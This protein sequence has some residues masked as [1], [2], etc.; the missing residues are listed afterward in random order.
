MKRKSKTIV[1]RAAT[2]LL[3]TM[4]TLLAFPTKASAWEYQNISGTGGANANEQCANLFDG[5]T[6]TKWCVIDVNGR[7]GFDE[8]DFVDRKFPI[9]VEFSTSTA[10][11]PT[12]YVLTTGN[13]SGIREDENGAVFNNSGRRPK[14]WVIWAKA[15]PNDNWEELTTVED[16]NSLPAESC[17]PTQYSIIIDKSYQFFRFEITEIQGGEVFELSEFQLLEANHEKLLS[18]ATVLDFQTSYQYTGNAITI[19]SFSLKDASG[20]DI[21]SSNY[22]YTIKNSSNE[23]VQTV[24][25]LGVYTLEISAIEGSEYSGTK[26]VSFQVV[27]WAGDGG[28]CGNTLENVYYEIATIDDKKTLTIR[29]SP[30]ATTDDLSMK[31]YGVNPYVEG[32]VF[33]PWINAYPNYAFDDGESYFDYWSI[34]CDI[35]EVVIEEGVTS[36]G[37]GSFINC[38]YLTSVTIP[39]SV[40]SIGKRTFSDS[41]LTSITIP[42]SVTSIGDNAFEGC[43][44]LSTITIPNSVTS[45]GEYAFSWCE[46]LSTITI[47]N[48]VTSIGRNAFTKC[49]NIT[50]VYC[51]ANPDKLNWATCDYDFHEN[52]QFHVYKNQLVNYLTKFSNARAQ[53][54]GDIEAPKTCVIT[55]TAT[56]NSQTETETSGVHELPYTKKLSDFIISNNPESA[57]QKIKITNI[58][59][60]GDNVVVGA[61]NGWDASFTVTDEGTSTVTITLLFMEV[62]TVTIDLTVTATRVFSVPANL[63]NDA[64]WA[65]FYSSEANFQAPEGTQVFAVNLNGTTIS[66]TEIAD[67]IVNQGQGVVLKKTTEGDF[68]M[69]KT[70]S[71]S[72]CDYSTNSLTGTDKDVINLAN[73]YVLGSGEAGVGF[74]K[75]AANGAIKANRAYL[76]Y[77]G[78][79]TRDYFNFEGAT[80]ITTATNEPSAQQHHYDLMGRRVEQPTKGLYIL[81]SSQGKNGKKV[82]I[83]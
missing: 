39:N 22:T 26:T 68:V 71:S 23:E 47:P 77:E 75:L 18:Y 44:G 16:D 54:V 38:E 12:G 51:Y 36:I 31:D 2:T 78:P 72:T 52:T 19:S 62:Q 20:N 29:K 55:V 74:Y 80:A 21:D 83:K 67:G 13:D 3:L 50:D 65:T 64:Y 4:L 45:I 24:V 28:F 42:N 58:E 9:W 46:N 15:D 66:L 73:V 35:Q 79:L 48:S 30:Y 59:S 61:Q 63:A 11:V 53:F 27:L 40:T 49:D 8:N 56:M 32:S 5:N 60:V 1:A 14:S 82:M 43:R 70:A 10:I 81:R 7:E 37:S 6:S 17:Q 41:G 69:T 57:M 76:T 33:A 25:E 34:S